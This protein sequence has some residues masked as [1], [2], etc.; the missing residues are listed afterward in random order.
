MESTAA[1]GNVTRQLVDMIGRAIIR[2]EFAMGE[3]LS[4]KVAVSDQYA[5]S[6]TVTCEAIKMLT[7]KGLVRSWPRRGMIVQHERDWNLYAHSRPP[8]LCFDGSLDY[9]VGNEMLVEAQRDLTAEE[10]A[11]RLRELPHSRFN[12]GFQSCR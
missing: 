1:R 9:M 10:A 3:N 12:D 8:L 2:G 7:A 4:T 5:V 11:E 6:R